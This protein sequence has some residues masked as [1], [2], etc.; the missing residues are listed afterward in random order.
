MPK[1]PSGKHGFDVF[2][3]MAGD[4]DFEIVNRGR[5]VQREGG[6]VAALHQV[7]QHRREPA[8]DDVPAQAPQDRSLRAVAASAIASTTRRNE[9]AARMCGSESSQRRDS[10]ALQRMAWRNPRREPCRRAPRWG[11]CSGRVKIQRL[12]AVFAHAGAFMQAFRLRSTSPAPAPVWL[13]LNRED[14]LGRSRGDD[15]AALLAA[16]RAQVDNP[17]RRS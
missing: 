15:M 2:A 11:S 7:D 16:F 8:L 14:L 10:G 6:G 12:A 4:G 17:V 9:S 3:G 5:A 1:R 13:F